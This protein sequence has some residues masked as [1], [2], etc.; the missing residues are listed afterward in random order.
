ML[1]RYAKGDTDRYRIRS[2]NLEL[3]TIIEKI[4][5]IGV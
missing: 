5:T 3:V 2:D 4:L 1:G